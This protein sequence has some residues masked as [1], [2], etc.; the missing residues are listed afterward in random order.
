MVSGNASGGIYT[1]TLSVELGKDIWVDIGECPRLVISVG[2]EVPHDNNWGVT[3]YFIEGISQHEE[4]IRVGGLEVGAVLRR[5]VY[6]EDVEVL[7]EADGCCVNLDGQAAWGGPV[8][9]GRGRSQR[10]GDQDSYS[11]RVGT[12]QGGLL[13]DNGIMVVSLLLN[14]LFR[15]RMS[16][17]NA[18]YVKTSSHSGEVWVLYLGIVICGFVGININNTVCK[19]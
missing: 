4:W 1:V 19:A 8:A 7:G 11:T 9:H 3:R 10:I 14:I 12:G 5:K 2:V 16:L 15:G 17:S 18:N 13:T 6:R